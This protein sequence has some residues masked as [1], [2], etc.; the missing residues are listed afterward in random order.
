MS[1]ILSKNH[2]KNTYVFKNYLMIGSGL[3]RFQGNKLNLKSKS[4]FY[5]SFNM[6]INININM[7]IM[8][9]QNFLKT[10]I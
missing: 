3:Q 2:I 1:F 9:Y 6:N 8:I 5:I 7:F 10:Q 4:K